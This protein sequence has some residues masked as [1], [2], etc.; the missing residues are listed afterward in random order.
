MSY[1]REKKKRSPKEQQSKCG[2]TPNS[3]VYFVERQHAA[4]A[5]RL[6]CSQQRS[7]DSSENESE[8]LMMRR[9]MRRNA[10]GGGK[11]G[12]P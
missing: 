4:D 1:A 9:M 7:R 10:C 3:T 2:K 6:H 11:N 8:Q 12:K 5:S